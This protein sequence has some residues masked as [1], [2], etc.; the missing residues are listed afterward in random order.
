MKYEII[1]LNEI[2]NQEYI[3]NLRLIYFHEILN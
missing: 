1:I 3:F 2:L